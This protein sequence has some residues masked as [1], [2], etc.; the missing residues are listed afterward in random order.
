MKKLSR[1]LAAELVLALAICLLAL[2]AGADFTGEI[3]LDKADCSVTLLLGDGSGNPATDLVGGKIAL[4]RVAGIRKEEKKYL[5]DPAE[6]QFSGS[7]NVKNI[8]DMNSSELEKANAGVAKKLEKESAE[9]KFRPQAETP[10]TDGKAVFENLRVGLYLFVQSE[11]SQGQRKITPF[12]LSVPSDNGGR[13]DS[14]TLER[15]YH[16]TAAPKAGYDSPPPTLPVTTPPQTTTPATTLPPYNT[17]THSTTPPGPN[18]SGPPLPQTGQLWW[19]VPVL[20]V[21]GVGL[22]ALGVALRC[23][24]KRD[25]NAE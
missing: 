7:E 18:R 9:K 4:Y 5:Y 11:Q 13:T 17:P 10:I 6:G 21:L 8:A 24:G 2:P 15:S 20:A 16:V 1:I 19:P 25:K 3:D 12:L 14:E 23:R 22:I